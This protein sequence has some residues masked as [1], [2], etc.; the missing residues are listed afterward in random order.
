MNGRSLL[1]RSGLVGLVALSLAGC[2]SL[3]PAGF[4][5]SGIGRPL[6]TKIGQSIPTPPAD[7]QTRPGGNTC[8]VLTALGWRTINLSG[9]TAPDAA[10]NTIGATRDTARK[11]P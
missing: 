1:L 9:V 3:D 11:C 2:A 6:G 10:A 4:I 5:G 8:E 7:V